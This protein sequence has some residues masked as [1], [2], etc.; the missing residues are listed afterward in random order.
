[1]YRKESTTIS[2][3]IK[4]FMDNAI[5]VV[6]SEKIVISKIADPIVQSDIRRRIKTGLYSFIKISRLYT[7]T[8][9]MKCVSYAYSNLDLSKYITSTKDFIILNMMKFT[10]MLILLPIKVLYLIKCAMRA[11]IT[12]KNH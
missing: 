2:V 12:S 6:E 4:T 1:M 11:G 9:S 5:S 10:P 3:D 8:D 7:I